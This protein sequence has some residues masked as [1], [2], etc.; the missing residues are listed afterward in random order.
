MKLRS[1]S[2]IVPA[3]GSCSHFVVMTL[4]P[5]NSPWV[6][7][8]FSCWA[9]F[10][11]CLCRQC[12]LVVDVVCQVTHVIAVLDISVQ[13]LVRIVCGNQLQQIQEEEFR[14]DGRLRFSIVNLVGPDSLGLQVWFF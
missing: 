4:V 1:L 3:L 10:I 13:E 9:L 11:G 8:I 12:C 2:R 6:G 5:S 14:T 7:P